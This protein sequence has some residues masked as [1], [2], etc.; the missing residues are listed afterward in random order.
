MY[1]EEA[2]SLIT[3]KESLTPLSST[4]AATDFS[5]MFLPYTKFVFLMNLVGQVILA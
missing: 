4:V 5:Y 3:S 2:R 1:K